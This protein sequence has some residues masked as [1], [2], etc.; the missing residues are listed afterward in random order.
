MRRAR[1]RVVAAI[2]VVAAG[3]ELRAQS[4]RVAPADD[5]SF[6][7]ASIKPYRGG[8]TVGGLSFGPREVRL[9]GTTFER[10]LRVAYDHPNPYEIRG[11]PAWISADR[12]DIVGLYPA[13]RTMVDLPALLRSLLR[14]RLGLQLHTDSKAGPQYELVMAR[15]DRRLGPQLQLALQECPPAEKRGAAPCSGTGSSK[16]TLTDGTVI[17]TRHYRK[18]PMDWL[19][20]ELALQLQRPIVD[21]TDL[22]GDYDFDLT[23][24]NQVLTA[25]TSPTGAAPT[26]FDALE[27]QLGLKLV[28]RTGPVPVLVIDR[29]E[30][31]T[32][33]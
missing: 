17:A 9:P 10:Q 33:D 6:E 11:A 8:G 15:P 12:F 24:D 14:D 29:I 19:I 13:G 28:S 2:V 22:T 5:P 26:I 18:L 20:R 23:Y 16:R 4:Q 1:L 3:L 21:R 30:R 31:P 7:V 25:A 27:R 32:P